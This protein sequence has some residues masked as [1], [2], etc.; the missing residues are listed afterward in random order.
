MADNHNHAASNRENVSS[1]Q[2]WTSFGLIGAVGAAFW[3]S[4]KIASP[5]V[6]TGAVAFGA[7]T[8]ASVGFYRVASLMKNGRAERNKFGRGALA[9][10]A[11]FCALLALNTIPDLLSKLP[12]TTYYKE[13]GVNQ[14]FLFPIALAA[15]IGGFLQN[16]ANTLE[17]MNAPDA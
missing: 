15:G 4:N 9:G 11:L 8:A 3:L 13:A 7:G 1:E 10:S 12:E 2:K 16:R 6:M 17:N 5:Y 14:S